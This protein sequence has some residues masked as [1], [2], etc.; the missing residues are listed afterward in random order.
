MLL[1]SF[2]LG[3]NAATRFIGIKQL[4]GTSIVAVSRGCAAVLGWLKTC[5]FGGWRLSVV[6]FF[7]LCSCVRAL[8]HQ[9]GTHCWAAEVP[10]FFV[11]NLLRLAQHW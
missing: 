6:F 2:S 11:L 1:P 3:W 9:C 7:F 8:S 10:F 4:A 5:C